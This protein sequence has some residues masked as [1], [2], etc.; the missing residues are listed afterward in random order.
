[1]LEQRR[2]VDGE[3]LE[4]GVY[5]SQDLKRG[6]EDSDTNSSPSPLAPGIL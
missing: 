3:K 6:R 1:M 4:D 5:L 2:E